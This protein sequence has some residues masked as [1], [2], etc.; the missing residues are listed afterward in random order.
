MGIILT[1]VKEIEK[2]LMFSLRK[3]ITNMNKKR[4]LRGSFKE[5][6]SDEIINGDEFEAYE[7][8]KCSAMEVYECY[9]EYFNLTIQ[10]PGEKKRVAVGA[11]WV[12]D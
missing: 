6:G 3:R 7:L 12:E 11:S 4:L 1:E 10:R 8:N 9:I 2:F 5:V